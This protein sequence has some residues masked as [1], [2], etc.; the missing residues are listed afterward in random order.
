MT[1][2]TTKP[3]TRPLDRTTESPRLRGAFTALVTP[4]TRR[5]RR[6]TKPPSGGSSAGRSWP[7]STASSRAARPARRRPCRPTSASGSSRTTVEVVGRASVARPHPGHRRDRHERHAGH[8]R[9][10]PSGRRAGCGRGAR[11]RAL[12]QPAR[13]AGCSRPISGPSPTRATCRSSSTTSRRGPGANVDA[14]HVPAACRASADRRGQGGERQP[15][16]DRADLPRAAARRGRAGRRRRVDPA[17][18]R[19]GWRR[20]RVGGEQ[21]DPRSSSS[22]L[23]AAARPAT[24]IPPGGST[25]AGCRCSW[26][27]SP[28]RPNP[29]PAKA[30]L[31]LDGTARERR[32]ARAAPADGCRWPRRRWRSTLRTLGLVEAGG[33]R[34]GPTTAGGRGMTTPTL[35]ARPG[36]NAPQR[37]ASW[38]RSRRDAAS[39]LARPRRT[40]TDGASTLM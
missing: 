12:L 26:R 38:T 21:R 4:F 25:S 17:A 29:V 35:E 14:G 37:S 7:A 32:R 27:T 30:A 20:G 8:D 16:A 10:D 5:R 23:C 18:P 40:A 22:A 36:P 19:A 34:I 9:G 28:G 1:R 6:S 2:S 33:G 13:T 24:G 39:R 11:R 31:A 3:P 15:R